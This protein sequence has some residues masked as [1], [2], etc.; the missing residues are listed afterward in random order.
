VATPNRSSIIEDAPADGAA[1]MM[2]SASAR[3]SVQRSKSCRAYASRVDIVLGCALA[4]F[5]LLTVGTF[6]YLTA[7]GDDRAA[8]QRRRQSSGRLMKGA[9][10]GLVV[11]VVLFCLYIVIVVTAR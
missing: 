3:L 1:L 10:I 8:V 5:T 7:T 4:A 11:P 6:R 9:A 2:V